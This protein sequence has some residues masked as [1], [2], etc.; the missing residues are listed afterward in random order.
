VS[1]VVND[2]PYVSPAMRAEVQTA[3]DEHGY[4]PNLLARGLRQGRTGILTLLVPD[5]AVPISVNSPTRSLSA[6]ASWDSPS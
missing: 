3:L 6:R 4:K 1:N 5:I 2:F